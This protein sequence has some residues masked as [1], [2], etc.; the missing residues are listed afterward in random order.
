ME[1]SSLDEYPVA[2]SNKN[3]GLNKIEE[4]FLK[5]WVDLVKGITLVCE[6]FKNEEVQGGYS[7]RTK[8][9]IT[10]LPRPFPI[11]MVRIVYL[12]EETNAPQNLKIL[13]HLPALVDYNRWDIYDNHRCRVII[14]GWLFILSRPAAVEAGRPFALRPS[15]SWLEAQF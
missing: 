13:Y 11:I 7:K 2:L 6:F 12:A 15:N 3:S 10:R 14:E 8:R 9:T 4:M 1:A 5:Q